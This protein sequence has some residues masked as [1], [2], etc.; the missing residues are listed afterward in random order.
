MF[1]WGGSHLRPPL[2]SG[3]SSSGAFPVGGGRG[4]CGGPR[5][6]PTGGGAEGSLA[7][8]ASPSSSSPSWGGGEGRGGEGPG[9]PSLRPTQPPAGRRRLWGRPISVGRAR[10]GAFGGPTCVRRAVLL[11]LAR[12]FHGVGGAA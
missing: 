12:H 6:G 5:G 8:P 7:W 3:R 4:R 10:A 2:T 1:N 11:L 9:R